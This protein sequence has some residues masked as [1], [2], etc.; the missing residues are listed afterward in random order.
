MQGGRRAAKN[1]AARPEGPA[2]P[3]LPA[4]R[5]R[6]PWPPS[7]AGRRWPSCPSGS[8]STGTLGWLAWLVLHL[9]YLVG[10]HNRV[11]VLTNWAWNYLTWDRSNR[12]II[13]LDEGD[14]KPAD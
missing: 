8:A 4:T 9:V 12:V 13:G 2:H 11:S 5:T 1:I 10:F 3:G 6:G 7:A 14:E